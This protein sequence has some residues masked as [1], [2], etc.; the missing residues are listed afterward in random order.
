VMMDQARV[1]REFDFPTAM[2]LPTRDVVTPD[3]VATGVRRFVEVLGRPAVLYVKHDGY[4]D[5]DGVKRLMSDGLLSWVKYAV[6]RDDPAKDAFL[7]K[8]V[9]AVGP[10]RIVSGIGEQPAVVHMR[11]FGL[12]SFTSG[13]V[14]VAPGLSMDMLRTV[15]KGD[16]QTAEEIRAVFRP[17]EDL[18]NSINPVRVLHAAVTLVG[19]A[20]MGP[21]LPLLSEVGAADVPAIKEAAIRLLG[22]GSDRRAA[23]VR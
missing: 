4:I 12:A 16:M 11:D 5:V 2:V 13:C 21:I 8:L 1:L 6:V 23:G 22:Q 17:L 18:R 10:E 14:C 19:I 3:G 7:R 9:D 15:R 20:D